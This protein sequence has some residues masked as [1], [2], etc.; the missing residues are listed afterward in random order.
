MGM[1]IEK[2]TQSFGVLIARTVRPLD[3]DGQQSPPLFHDKVHFLPG[4]CAPE[5]ET[6]LGRHQFAQHTQM[7]VDQPLKERILGDFTN[8]WVRPAV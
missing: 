6:G 4:A 3:L 5:V 2:S 8:R 7:L 1:D